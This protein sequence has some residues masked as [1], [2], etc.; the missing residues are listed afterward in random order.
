M[1]NINCYG[2]KKF[3]RS[4]LKFAICLILRSVMA[5]MCQDVI[6]AKKTAKLTV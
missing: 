5:V 3:A 6:T 4:P 2:R 1:E